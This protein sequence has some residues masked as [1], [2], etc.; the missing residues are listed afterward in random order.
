[1]ILIVCF[2]IILFSFEYISKHYLPVPKERF[3]IE[4]RKLGYYNNIGL[5][6]ENGCW[7]GV[8]VSSVPITTFGLSDHLP[9]ICNSTDCHGGLA[10][11][12]HHVFQ[13]NDSSLV[14]V[15]FK[16]DEII[17]LLVK[18]GVSECKQ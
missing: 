4:V 11:T 18:E 13:W 1:M 2:L 8:V 12:M 17:T 9:I 7:V 3:D 14:L 15:D 6:K 5:V 16:R 10:L